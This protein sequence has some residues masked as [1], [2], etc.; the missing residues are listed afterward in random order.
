[1]ENRRTLLPVAC[2]R[3]RGVK[4][5]TWPAHLTKGGRASLRDRLEER[6][7]LVPSQQ[8]GALSFRPRGEE[9]GQEERPETTKKV[10]DM[11]GLWHMSHRGGGFYSPKPLVCH[12][13]T[14]AWQEPPPCPPAMYCSVQQNKGE[15]IMKKDSQPGSGSETHFSLLSL[16]YF[17]FLH[18]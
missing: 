8:M 17:L 18:N 7:N 13:I 16:L 5:E 4:T 10:G 14:Q 6:N 3:K 12:H 1:M 2:V 11:A 15:Y 9:G